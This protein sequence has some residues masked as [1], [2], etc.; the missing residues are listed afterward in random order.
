MGVKLHRCL[1]CDFCSWDPSDFCEDTGNCWECQNVI[2][3]VI[4]EFEDD[5]ELEDGPLY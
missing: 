2:D 4:G 3:E 1:C 5:E